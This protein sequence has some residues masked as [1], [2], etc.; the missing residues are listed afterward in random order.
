MGTRLFWRSALERAAKT[1]AQAALTVFLGDAALNIINVNWPETAALAATAALTS[2]LTSIVSSG[3][4]PASS[5]SLVEDGS[6]TAAGPREQ[7]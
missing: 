1:A 4:G 3:V 6:G 5:P 2:L 7:I